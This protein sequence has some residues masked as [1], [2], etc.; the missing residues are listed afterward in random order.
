MLI[1][2]CI[3]HDMTIRMI[4][5]M[6]GINEIGWRVLSNSRHSF[7]E[8]VVEV[9]RYDEEKALMSCGMA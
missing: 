7:I 9:F 8:K 2:R 4:R 3:Y 5:S 1:L 6:G